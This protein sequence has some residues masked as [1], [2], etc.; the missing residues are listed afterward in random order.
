MP[1][2]FML[3]HINLWLLRDGSHWTLV[4]TGLNTPTTRDLW[5]AALAGQLHSEPISRVVV[6]HLHPDHV[7]C[8]GWLQ[9]SAGAA[10]DEP[11]RIPVV[12]H[13]GGRHGQAS[14]GRGVSFIPRRVPG[15][16]HGR[17]QHSALLASGLG[18]APTYNRLTDGMSSP[19]AS[20]AGRSWSGAAIRWN[21]PAW[22]VP[23]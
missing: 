2:P 1:L 12:P 22:S 4:D 17:Y 7:G 18:T 3:G 21:R 23:N 6:T 5:L 16:R 20:T 19:L 15:N 10:M 13:T 11:G 8:A 9:T 14:A